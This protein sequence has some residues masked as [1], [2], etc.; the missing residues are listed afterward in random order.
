M[1]TMR[2]T[3]A[4]LSR[5]RFFSLFALGCL[6]LSL[7]ACMGG[8]SGDS[9]K[10]GAPNPNEKKLAYGITVNAPASWTVISSISPDAASKES[11]D[12]RRQGGE[13]VLLLEIS[14]TASTKGL[15]PR[16]GVFLVN[17]K[18]NFMP[19]EYAEKLTAEEFASMSKDLLARERD[20]AKKKKAKSNVLDLQVSRDTVDGKLAILHRVMVTAPNGQPVRLLNWDIY[21]P[22]GAGIA[23]K[24]VCDP[25]AA[26]V[27][28]ELANLVRSMRIAQ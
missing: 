27:E 6:A 13:R 3:F 4:A 23:V 20:M 1:S 25:E 26:G 14:G 7:G 12:S 16:M 28:N 24:T 18:N 9:G 11:L 8:G 2:H 5:K 22:N 15:E 21:L 17:E 10:S 19:R